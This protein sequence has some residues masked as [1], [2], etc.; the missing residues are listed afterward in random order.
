MNTV[1]SDFVKSAD[2]AA[3]RV[4]LDTLTESD[5]TTEDP[6]GNQREP[7]NKFAYREFEYFMGP[8]QKENREASKPRDHEGVPQVQEVELS[9]AD[10]RS[11]KGGY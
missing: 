6:A 3:T 9:D 7:L 4:E 2:A 11:S 5:Y 8:C 1:K 10:E